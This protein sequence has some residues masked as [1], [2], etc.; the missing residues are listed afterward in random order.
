MK[1]F[2]FLGKE[3]YI[4]KDIIKE[5]K[6]YKDNICILTKYGEKFKIK[7]EKQND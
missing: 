3:T 5:I 4:N 1:G 2:M 7:K 6:E